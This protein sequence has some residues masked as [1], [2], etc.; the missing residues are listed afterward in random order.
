MHR[1]AVVGVVA[2]GVAVTVIVALDLRYVAVVNPLR[3]TISEHGLGPSGWLFGLAVGL[4]GIGSV[5]IAVSLA[6]RRLAPALSPGMLALAAWS[7]GMLVTAAFPK[8]DWSVGPSLNGSI[9][10]V[11]SIVAFLSLPIAALLISRPWRRHLAA[12]VVTWLG[13]GSL[14]WVA[15]ITAA[16][17]F[18]L[19]ND[20][21]WWRV[22]PLGV[23][24]RGLAITEVATLFALGVWAAGRTPEVGAAPRP[25]ERARPV[26]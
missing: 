17:G 20:M 5:A 25:V 26:S 21:P 24:E 16:I 22:M 23:V 15:G 7:V 9:H 6:R 1:A 19:W 18:A 13:L 2:V 3:R 8:H 4:V 14:L 12:R 10:R 11:G